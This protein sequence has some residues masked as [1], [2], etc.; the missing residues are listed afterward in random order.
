[1]KNLVFELNNC[2]SILADQNF[3]LCLGYYYLGTY[4]AILYIYYYW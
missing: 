3:V 4:I 2:S 1:M